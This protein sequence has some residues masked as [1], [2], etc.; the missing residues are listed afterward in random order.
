MQPNMGMSK[1]NGGRRTQQIIFAQFA[2]CTTPTGQFESV[3]HG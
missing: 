3:A 1:A 2:T